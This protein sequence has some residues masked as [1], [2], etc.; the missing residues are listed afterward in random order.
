MV[1]WL[2]WGGQVIVSGPTTL[3]TLRGSFLSKYLPAEA[4]GAVKLT[5]ASFRAMDDRFTVVERQAA[6]KIRRPLTVAEGRFVEGIELKKHADAQFVPHTGELLAE[7][8]VGRGRIVATA[9]PLTDRRLINWMN[10]DNFFNACLLRRPHR[11][12]GPVP[13][14]VGIAVNWAAQ[15]GGDRPNRLDARLVTNVRYFSRD[16]GMPSGGRRANPRSDDASDDGSFA[17]G[18][19]RQDD[20]FG[21]EEPVAQTQASGQPAGRG[22]QGGWDLASAPYFDS[23]FTACPT[24]GIAR[25]DDLSATSSQVRAALK[26][27]A[28]I[29]VPDAGFVFRVLGVYLLVLVPVNWALFRLIG[30]VEWAWLAAPMIAIGGAVSVVYL[31]QLDIGFVRSRTE[32]GLIELQGDYDRG[33]LTRYTAL[34]TSLST[35]YDFRFDDP[36]ALAVPFIVD[37]D[38]QRLVGD[39][40][41]EVSFVRDERVRLRGFPVRSN[42]TGMVHSEQMF[43][44]GGG[45]RLVEAEDGSVQLVNETDLTL[46]GAGVIRR[47]GIGGTNPIEVAW[48]GELE[49]G[50][51]GVLR[52]EPAGNTPALLPQWEDSP[53]TALRSESGQLSLR[54]LLDLAQDPQRLQQGDVRLIAWTDAPLRGLDIWP[55]GQIL[56]RT[57]VIAHLR[58]GPWDVPQSDLNTSR[59]T[60][61]RTGLPAGGGGLASCAQ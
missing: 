30:R 12:F 20:P 40:I 27:A 6:R 46:K 26:Q 7:R 56:H 24:C 23:G 10:F 50:T 28:G 8:R 25:W 21:G 2:H 38:F 13:N 43:P 59:D 55:R 47:V 18:G 51:G 1:D 44:L 17:R 48:L 58:Y 16:T 35:S 4:G 15:R 60:A 45:V 37:P 41:H 14:D 52:F 29:T 31:A 53:E 42:S 3:D 54:R 34:Y 39:P 11:E 9:F 19:A 49:P 57:L 22:G 5:Q 36:S 33:H 32:I 61:L